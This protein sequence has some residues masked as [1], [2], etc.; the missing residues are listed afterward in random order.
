MV[1]VQMELKLSEILPVAD[2]GRSERQMEN[3]F[4]HVYPLLEPEGETFDL[5]GNIP[6]AIGS[7]RVY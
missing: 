5:R 6:C 7:D 1:P 3:D 2:G 4:Q